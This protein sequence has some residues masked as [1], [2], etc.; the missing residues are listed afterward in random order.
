MTIWLRVSDVARLTSLSRRYWQRRFARGDVP[1]SRQVNFGSRRLF[2][3]NRAAFHPWWT[4]Q[5]TGIVKRDNATDA[6]ST[7][8]RLSP[9]TTTVLVPTTVA[10]RKHRR[11]VKTVIDARQHDFGFERIRRSTFDEDEHGS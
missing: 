9:A 2:L 3:V 4:T 7:F 5:M 11:S 1:G 6:I 8:G 10:R